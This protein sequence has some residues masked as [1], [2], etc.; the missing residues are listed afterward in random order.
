MSV[1]T[2][3][4]LYK[5]KL[6]IDDNFGIVIPKVKYVIEHED[7]YYA[8]ISTIAAMPIDLAVQLD[9]EG[10]AFEEIDEWDLFVLLFEIIRAQDTSQVFGDLDLSKFE[11]AVNN[12]TG[13]AFWEDKS[14]GL[15]ID[16]FV[17]AK[18]ANAIRLIHHLKKD[19]RTPANPEAKR[20]MLERMRKKQKRRK[21]RTES[22]QLEELIIAMVCTEQFKYNFESVLDLSIYQFN[23]SVRQIINKTDYDNRMIG[24]YTGNIDMKKI[25]QDDLN[26]LKHK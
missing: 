13:D 24:I 9:D 11:L 25:S 16:R 22:S 3:N 6:M 14:T 21:N 19:R 7:D 4:I 12:R 20:Y 26:W 1:A 5:N 2:Q 18:I 17:H 8:L 23:E 15:K 10:I